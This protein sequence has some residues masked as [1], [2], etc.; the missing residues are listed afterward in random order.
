MIDLSTHNEDLIRDAST[1]KP[2]N[3]N[4][5]DSVMMFESGSQSYFVY[6]GLH[7]VDV[8]DKSRGETPSSYHFDEDEFARLMDALNLDE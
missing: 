7:T 4:P 3:V 5:R 1:W 2:L 8:F 6:T